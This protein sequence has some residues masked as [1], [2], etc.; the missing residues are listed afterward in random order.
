MRPYDSSSR[1]GDECIEHT[2]FPTKHTTQYQV[3]L[4]PKRNPTRA[5]STK[6]ILAD[7]LLIFTLA[8]GCSYFYYTKVITSSARELPAKLQEER[9]IEI[10]WTRQHVE[11]LEDRFEDRKGERRLLDAQHIRDL[12][13]HIRDLERDLELEHVGVEN[14]RLEIEIVRA[15]NESTSSEISASSSST[16]SEY[17]NNSELQIAPSTTGLRGTPEFKFQEGDIVEYDDP[18]G[19]VSHNAEAH[20]LAPHTFQSSKRHGTNTYYNV[21]CSV[22]GRKKDLPERYLRPYVP[23]EKYQKASCNM[24]TLDAHRF[25]ECTVLHYEPKAERGA[26][27]LQGRYAVVV[28]ERRV[29]LPVW[30]VERLPL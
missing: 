3:P 20:L 7:A 6:W 9:I 21:V 8:L 1:N 15:H 17:E 4:P 26:V 16:S 27:V 25:R 10:S 13:Q 19:L 14:A 5:S 22:D 29:F 18:L 11:E 24:G 12:E 28:G 2:A 30:K 23:Y